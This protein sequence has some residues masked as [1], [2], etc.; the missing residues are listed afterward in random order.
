MFLNNVFLKKS[1]TLRIRK[2]Y[3]LYF[4]NQVVIVVFF[5]L[6]RNLGLISA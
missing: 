4:I 2:I 5:V 3:V 1:L 6:L